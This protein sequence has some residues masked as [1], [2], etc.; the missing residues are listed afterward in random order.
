MCVVCFMILSSVFILCVCVCVFVSDEVEAPVL[1]VN[2]SWPSSDPCSFTCKGSNITISSIY[3]NSSCSP[4][5][6]TSSNNHTLKLNCSDDHIMC[7]HSNPV[8]WK[9]GRKKVI[10]LCTV[11]KEPPQAIQNSPY[12]SWFIPLICLL[13]TSL[14]PLSVIGWCLYKRKKDHYS[15]DQQNELTVYEKVDDI[16]NIK[17]QPSPLETLEKSNNSCTLYDTVREHGPPDVTMETNQISPSDDSMNQSETLTENSK[18]NVPTTIYCTIQKQPKS[19]P[20]TI[21][22]VVN[23]QP[24]GDESIHPKPE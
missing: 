20:E 18:P 4:E 15:P 7:T 22:A 23:K 12:P 19:E 5:E 6:V 2:S 1:T 13:I 8:S 16:K 24:A 9:T 10:E 3:N 14:L 11:N 17:Q 21:Y